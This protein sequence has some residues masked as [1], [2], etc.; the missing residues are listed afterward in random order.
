LGYFKVVRRY[1]WVAFIAPVW[2][3]VT[4]PSPLAGL[5]AAVAFGSGKSAFAVG[6]NDSLGYIARRV[7]ADRAVER[8][9]VLVMAA[10]LAVSDRRPHL[11][12]ADPDMTS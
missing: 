3:E 6:S 2:R 1:A 7:D 8:R 11:F 9:G 10:V 4:K 12:A 5:L